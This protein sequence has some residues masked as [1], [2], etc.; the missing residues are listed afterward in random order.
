MSTEYKYPATDFD[1]R[2]LLSVLGSFWSEMYGGQKELVDLL[3]ARTEAEQQSFTNLLEALASV[4]RQDIPLLHRENWSL[5]TIRKSDMTTASVNAVRYGTVESGAY[6]GNPPLFYGVASSRYFQFP[7]PDKLVS[8]GTILNRLT[9]PSLVL[10]SGVDF[11]INSEHGSIVFAADPFQN[12]RL[13][14]RPVWEN[15]AVVDT[16]GFLW[17]FKAGYDWD[18]IYNNFGYVLGL[19]LKSSQAYKDLVNALFDCLVLGSTEQRIGYALSA[20]LGIPLV[21]ETEETVELI[22]QTAQAVTIVTDAHC[23]RFN[24]RVT[25]NVSVGDTVVA[26]QSLISG[27]AVEHFNTGVTPATLSALAVGEGFLAAGYYGDLQFNNE[28]VPLIIDEAHESGKTYVSFQLVG[29]EADVLQFFDQIHT[30][31]LA[32]NKTLAELLDVREV[33]TSEPTADTLPDTINPLKF[34]IENVLRGNTFFVRVNSA[35]FGD[36]VTTLDCAR[37]LRRIVPPRSGLIILID[38]PQQTNRIQLVDPERLQTFLG[39]EPIRETPPTP[40]TRLS[41]PS[42]II[43]G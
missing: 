14:T 9:E 18:F 33:V 1:R 32:A 13:P 3:Q 25:P 8:V 19:K 22:E 36:G 38:L 35:A 10:T 4:S 28:D 12:P 11:V 5:L 20:I 2:G 23:Y 16:E 6:A 37:L 21:L 7:L 30:R 41:A 15:G 24:P 39:G 27:F 17:C 42:T 29:R 26:G 43:T 31:G 34:L 40:Q